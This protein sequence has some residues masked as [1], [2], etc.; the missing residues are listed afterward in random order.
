MKKHKADTTASH[1]KNERVQ[2]SVN[3]T[4]RPHSKTLLCMDVE[5]RVF[6]SILSVSP[7]G[8][9]IARST[10]CPSYM[11]IEME[12]NFKV[13]RRAVDEMDLVETRLVLI[14]CSTAVTRLCLLSTTH[15]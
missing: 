8:P 14:V 9:C 4:A 2:L 5:C 7:P 3:H 1:G 15:P 6:C 10:L 12:V 11:H 13:G